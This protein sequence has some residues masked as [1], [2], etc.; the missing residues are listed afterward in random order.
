MTNGAS[1]GRTEVHTSTAST[2]ERPAGDWDLPSFSTPQVPPGTWRLRPLTVR[3]A[4]ALDG[5]FDA[6]GEA[7]PRRSSLPGRSPSAMPGHRDALPRFRW[8]AS[9]RVD[10][11]D[12]PDPA[13]GGLLVK[14]ITQ[15]RTCGGT[16]V[17]GP[18]RR[19]SS[20]PASSAMSLRRR[21]SPDH[22][23]IR[24]RSA[25]SAGTSRDPANSRSSGICSE[26]RS[27]LSL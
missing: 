23:T 25:T 9:V 27:M 8:S 11:C 22:N 7:R 6:I 19:F 4:P 15:A 5:R 10:Q 24:A 12:R 2:E 1:H 26:E 18:P 21:P 16:W 13:D 17:R 20:Q 14:T 3:T